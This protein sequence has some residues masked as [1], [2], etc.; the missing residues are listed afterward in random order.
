[1]EVKEFDLW[2]NPVVNP[3]LTM[4]DYFLIPPFSI[5]YTVD[6]VWQE[7]KKRWNRLI[8]DLG[9][10]R[11]D[12][13]FINRAKITEQKNIA[14][15][16][17]L[18]AVMSEILLKWFTEEGFET[19][20]PFAGDTVFGFVSAWLKR[21]FT[22]IELRPEQAE[23]NQTQVD[24][25]NLNARYICDTAENMDEHIEDN[26]KDFIFS[27]PPYADLEKYSDLP[28]DLSNMSHDDFFKIYKT[29]LQ[30][31]YKK[32]KRNRFAVIVISEVRGKNGGYIGLVPRTIDFMTEAGYLYY[33]EIILVN[34]VGSLPLRTGKAMNSGRK[35]GRRHQNILVFF[36]GD[37]KE[38]KKD[39]SELIPK[40]NYYNASTNF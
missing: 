12:V 40:N 4:A 34:Q 3:K 22:G 14:T 20:D 1:M 26:S 37:Q 8:G 32:L 21:P 36:K 29:V 39:F 10:A 7:R 5:F 16:S 31:T 9:Q 25:N 6:G 27:C 28:R 30:N 19:F 33:N 11:K 24:K 23:F 17:I 13:L 15:T 18:D 2:G 35:V 38:I